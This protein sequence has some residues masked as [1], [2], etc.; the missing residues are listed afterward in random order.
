M[1]YN[2]FVIGSFRFER[3]E[4]GTLFMVRNEGENEGEGT[5]VNEDVLNKV[6]EK[7]YE[8]VF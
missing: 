6:L 4:D 3:W 7:F 8:E 5:E 2:V 1:D